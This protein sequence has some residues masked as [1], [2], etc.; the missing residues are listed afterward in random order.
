M[1]DWRKHKNFIKL[2][3]QQLNQS[4][5][6]LMVDAPDLEVWKR[7]IYEFILEWMND[8]NKI[9]IKTSGSTGE[10]KVIQLEKSTMSTSA[11]FTGNYLKLNKDAK[12]LLALPVD[13]I[14][15][16]MMIIRAFVLGLDLHIQ[17]ARSIINTKEKYDLLA[18]TPFQFMQSFNNDSLSLDK[19]ENIIIGGAASGVELVNKAQTLR[20]SCFATYGMTETSSH[21][22]LQ[23]L[24]GKD[25][26]SNFTLIHASIR[27]RTDNDNCLQI[28]APYLGE[29]SITTNDVVQIIDNKTFKWLGRKDNVI[30][31]G[32]IKIY[33]EQIEARINEL[34]NE[35]MIIFGLDDPKLGEKVCLLIESSDIIAG[36]KII[37][38]LRPILSTYEL[39]AVHQF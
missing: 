14:G 17:E 31:S 18:L 27:I 5:I 19:F 12:A 15:G 10:P 21:I 34:F 22:A 4:E 36:E 7:K 26:S 32:G 28:E 3:G 35:R 6:E 33:P 20:S 37:L 2:D 25:A 29:S 11:H 16:K 30:N 9:D 13:F 39:V 1:I 38:A 24:N 23:K 8:S